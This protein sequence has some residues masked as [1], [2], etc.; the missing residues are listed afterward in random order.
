MPCLRGSGGQ[1]PRSAGREFAHQG[2]GPG[3]SGRQGGASRGRSTCQAQQAG[4]LLLPPA[5]FLACPGVP[6]SPCGPVPEPCTR[7]GI[8]A[9]LLDEPGGGLRTAAVG[10]RRPSWILR[11]V[12]G[13]GGAAVIRGLECLAGRAAGLLRKVRIFRACCLSVRRRRRRRP[14]DPRARTVSPLVGWWLLLLKS[15]LGRSSGSLMGTVAELCA[16]G[17]SVHTRHWCNAGC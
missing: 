13:P 5:L 17:G 14:V 11:Q 4:G 16:H 8:P 10:R 12:V 15:S 2:Q 3:R 7:P 1:N 9:F 6:A